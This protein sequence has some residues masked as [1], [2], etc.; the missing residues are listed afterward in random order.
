MRAGGGADRDP[1][2]GGRRLRA[3]KLCNAHCQGTGLRFSYPEWKYLLRRSVKFRWGRGQVTN[4]GVE[5][6]CIRYCSHSVQTDLD[7]MAPCQAAEPHRVVQTPSPSIP[8]RHRS[9]ARY[10]IDG[11]GKSS[12]ALSRKLILILGQSIMEVD[13]SGWMR[14]KA[15]RTKQVVSHGR[16]TVPDL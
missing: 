10:A 14:T 3:T 1:V 13:H 4:E 7:N 5:V 8:Q 12:I 2:S 11:H 16:N 15:N 6:K 9:D